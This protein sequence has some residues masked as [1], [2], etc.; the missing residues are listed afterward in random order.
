MAK[1]DD[2]ASFLWGKW[3]IFSG[4]FASFQGGKLYKVGPTS[5]KRSYNPYKWPH[6]WVPAVITLIVGVITPFITGFLGPPCMS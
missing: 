3:P 4:R 6:K 5:Y 1:G 2:S